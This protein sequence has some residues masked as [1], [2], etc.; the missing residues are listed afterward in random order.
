MDGR[1]QR[2]LAALSTHLRPTAPRLRASL[3]H[4]HRH[5]RHHSPRGGGGGGGGG[6][7]TRPGPTLLV[8]RPT[9][10]GADAAAADTTTFVRIGSIAVP[11]GIPVDPSLVP[12]GYLYPETTDFPG[13]AAA[14]VA[15]TTSTTA[16]AG[17]ASGAAQLAGLAKRQDL[18]AALQFLMKK[19]LLKQDVFLVGPPGPVRRRIALAYCELLRR[20]VE[21]LCVS[22][23]V[24]ESDIKQR[25]EIQSRSAV[26]VDAAAVRAAL[27]G[28][29]LVV[30]G[31]EKAERNVLPVINNLLENREMA[32]EDGRFIVSSERYAELRKR[33]GDDKIRQWSL[34][35][36]HPDFF[37]IA[38]GLPTPPYFGNPLDPPL[39]SRFQARSEG[40][41]RVGAQ[42]V[43][44]R[45]LAPDINAAVLGRLVSVARVIQEL[46]RDRERR[47]E[48][49]DFPQASLAVAVRMLGAAA[50]A[51]GNRTGAMPFLRYAIDFTYP[52]PQLG[53]LYLDPEVRTAILALYEQLGLLRDDDGRGGGGGGGGGESKGDATDLAARSAVVSVT[54]VA[55]GLRSHYPR[56]DVCLESGLRFSVP[57]GHAAESASGGSCTAPPLRDDGGDSSGA[58]LVDASRVAIGDEV[59]LCTA[60]QLAALGRCVH[61]HAVGD[62]CIV[63][64]KGV[65]K[66]FL[67]RAFSA[68]CGYGQAH[69]TLICLYKDMTTRD[70]FESRRTRE[71]GDTYWELSP[72]LK[73]SLRGGL[74][75]LDGVEQIHPATLAALQRLVSD[76]EV[77]LPSG[78]RFM[79]L[80]RCLA[81]LRRLD[82]TDDRTDDTN[83]MASK[84]L[85]LQDTHGVYAIHPSFRIV[86]LARPP[87]AHRGLERGSW[88]TAEVCTLFP[89]VW[90]RPLSPA[91]EKQVVLS[92]A[93]R[94][95]VGE[96]DL[97]V[98]LAHTLRET[99]AAQRDEILVSISESLST[100]QLIR[101]CRQRERYAATSSLHQGLHR[102]CL[103]RFM[104][105]VVKAALEQCLQDA[106][107]ISAPGQS[108]L[109]DSRAEETSQLSISTERG[110]GGGAHAAQEFLVIGPVRYPL[111]A[112]PR[113]PLLVPHLL[114][115]NNP[116]QTRTLMEMLKDF[117]VGEHLLLIGNQG[118]GKNKLADKFL[119]LLRLPREYIQ[120]HRDTTVSQ[121]TTQPSVHDGQLVFEDSPLVRAARE[122]YVLV[123]D[124]ADKAPTHVTALLKGL[125]EDRE[126]MLGDGRRIRA[127][128]TGGRSS[129]GA[130]G[131]A[132][133]AAVTDVALHPDFRMIVLANRPGF[134][135]LGNDFF[136][137]VGSVF[138]TFAVDN[139]DGASELDLLRRYAANAG[140]GGA[141]AVPE[142]TLRKLVAAFAELRMHVE[143]GTL[144]YPYSTRELVNAVRHLSRFPDDGI[145]QVL[146]NIFDFD[147]FQGGEERDL[148]VGAFRRQGIVLDSNAELQISLGV[149]SVLPPVVLG[150]EWTVG[151]ARR[152][153]GG[154]QVVECVRNELLPHTAGSLGG[155]DAALALAAPEHVTRFDLR[156]DT[157]G[158]AEFRFEVPGR[159]NVCG[160]VVLDSGRIV[161]A[162]HHIGEL[163]LEL[164]DLDTN[165]A[166]TLERGFGCPPAMPGRSVFRPAPS[167]VR[168]FKLRGERFL[169]HNPRE[170]GISLVDASTGLVKHYV[171]P[172]EKRT[173]GGGGPG[174]VVASSRVVV[175]ASLNEEML[176]AYCAGGK[177]LYFV[178]FD[179]GSPRYNQEKGDRLF[180]VDLPFGL[181]GVHAVS[182]ELW[183]LQGPTPN[184]YYTLQF[185]L[186][187]T[188]CRLCPIHRRIHALSA[189]GPIRSATS[190]TYLGR[191][192]NRIE[193]RAAPPGMHDRLFRHALTPGTHA[194]VMP[195]LG[196][197]L[198]AMRG[199]R[200][201]VFSYV[202]QSDDGSVADEDT[203]PQ[204]A[205]FMRRSRQLVTVRY[206]HQART[207]SSGLDALPSSAL[208]EVVSVEEGVVRKVRVPIGA[209]MPDRA[210]LPKT[211]G[212]G[213]GA[214]SSSSSSSS[215]VF[216]TA[217]PR[218]TVVIPR[219]KNTGLWQSLTSKP[220]RATHASELKD[221]RLLFVDY[222]GSAYVLEVRTE[223]IMRGLEEWASMVGGGADGAGGGLDVGMTVDGE[224]VDLGEFQG[225]GEDGEDGEG[226]GEGEGDGKGKGQ[227]SGEGEGEGE[228]SGDGKGGSGGEGSGGSG[229]AMTGSRKG[230]PNPGELPAPL[231]QFEGIQDKISEG[232]RNKRAGGAPEGDDLAPEVQEQ[233]RAAKAAAWKRLLDKMDM[234]EADLEKYEAYRRQV[235]TE[236]RQLRVSL[237]ALEARKNERAWLRNKDA[238]DLDDRR[239]IDGLTGSRNIYKARGEQ[240]PS[241][242]SFQELPKRIHFL[243]DLSMSM[244]RYAMDGRLQRSLESATMVMEAFR[245]FDHKFSYKIGGH[246]GDSERLV[247]VEEGKPPQND[248]E[249]LQVIRKMHAHSDLC[250][251][252]D[253]TLTAVRHSVKEIVK[254]EADEYAVFLF[255]DANLEQYGIG[256]GELQEILQL[257]QR[258]R[259]F[260]IFIGSL[261][262]QAVRLCES[263]PAGQVF[264]ALNTR[265]IPTIVKNCLSVM[266]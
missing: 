134:P 21:Y 232:L 126:M 196:A 53:R 86:A 84:L 52:F 125:A 4:V 253:N 127:M 212:G 68:L 96:L 47:I 143:E 34:V 62:F 211:N 1:A 224:E 239:L 2:R 43:E 106:G 26:Y 221:G 185:G 114:F 188:R 249:R 94:V 99:S 91:E 58:A 38:I 263:M 108:L 207:S 71:S 119:Q 175:S 184:A 39:R 190:V 214:P 120:L 229:G 176:A 262:D 7:R 18:L 35:R 160:T 112:T 171:V 158:E 13:A 78:K 243:F 157:F 44:A 98:G 237:E 59:R 77:S 179:D 245:N 17:G 168:L 222:S 192:A 194:Q 79:S 117:A 101:L 255:S 28:R 150:E 100:R 10:A 197:A 37:V 265:D 85:W 225:G 121:L 109:S 223:E 57:M 166:R 133:A 95:D 161:V 29:V 259:V 210:T 258:V 209:A 70:L 45:R 257:D 122:G 51:G 230:N 42:L 75:V 67:A 129:S 199:G 118:V 55:D 155:G 107:I 252:G 242:G 27:Y 144:S 205:L 147:K 181:V 128:P 31:I 11:R 218:R 260:I 83:D 173:G 25:R 32:L 236:I 142:A 111:A 66:S 36:A 76:R 15:A 9:A 50:A 12:C 170:H 215:S 148:L 178:Y 40:I 61:A 219:S 54:V 220:S 88:M 159:G 81:L 73:L 33:H 246:S 49:P 93:P 90:V 30:D 191:S 186:R 64:P 202:R 48:I 244:S 151:D 169:V 146:R 137:V 132:A 163:D 217:K 261:G 200:V 104:P 19:Q 149:V 216:G 14:T 250:D 254:R 97:L 23:D 16:P 123:V 208:V 180:A 82:R 247:F 138:S 80:G 154:V 264:V 92:R 183:L 74:A 24:T 130:T 156:A 116:R 213:G 124:E 41:P 103:S 60:Y 63:G 56:G 266:V 187:V 204:A 153:A 110:S 251:S 6:R 198:A 206:L 165:E 105:S 172:I 115:Y 141:S 164:V 248:R 228:G 195:G 87:S 140:S 89:F 72:L 231:A 22:P 241:L 201:P 3:E 203:A 113:A 69:T 189:G 226:G 193:G 152:S 135:F 131:A 65:G 162:R 5:H 233:V 139:P 145:A 167:T 227:G 174:G 102:L 256:A 20:E 136:K 240:P 234:D 46:H 8:R 177:R 238:G 235:A 182:R